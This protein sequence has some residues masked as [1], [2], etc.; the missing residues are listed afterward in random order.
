MAAGPAAALPVARCPGG[1]AGTLPVIG[2]PL[3]TRARDH[4]DASAPARES[5]S[6]GSPGRSRVAEAV[7]F[8]RRLAPRRLRGGAGAPAGAGSPRRAGPVDRLGHGFVEGAIAAEIGKVGGL[9]RGFVRDR[10]GVS[11][12]EFALVAPVLLLLSL[13]TV[14]VARFALLA[15]KLQHA[16]T[17]MADLAT[18]EEELT[19]ATLDGL[20]A[21]A[22]HITAPFDLV[23]NGVVIVSGVTGADGD[24]PTVAWQRRGGEL[25]ASSGIGAVGGA[26]DLPADLVLDDGE[27]VVAAEVVFLHRPW[28]LGLVPQTILRRL[29]FYRPRLG[30]LGE[31]G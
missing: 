3:P 31:L 13:G 12:V 1:G 14:E 11:A 25:Q 7:G 10:R 24:E 9:S 26:A 19:T 27:T 29:A 23:G 2:A 20:F 17:T 22:G 21:A 28:L 4:A 18:R 6:G 16:A 15:L 5:A 30:T 8:L